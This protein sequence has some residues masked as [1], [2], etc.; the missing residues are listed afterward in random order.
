M[1]EH[2][3]YY[4]IRSRKFMEFLSVI[5]IMSLIALVPDILVIV[6]VCVCVCVC[7]YVLCVCVCVCARVHAHAHTSA[8]VCVN[9]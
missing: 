3:N 9:Q 1:E 5:I 8:G 6:C 7:V 4:F 2:A